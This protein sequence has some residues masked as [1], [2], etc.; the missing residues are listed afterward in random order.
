[1]SLVL[2]FVVSLLGG[3]A[4]SPASAA[5]GID[6]S[7]QLRHYRTGMGVSVEGYRK[8]G[9]AH[10]YENGNTMTI[11]W[12]SSVGAYEIKEKSTGLCLDTWYDRDD[13]YGWTCSGARSQR[14][15]AV[16]VGDRKDN[17]FYQQTESMYKLV[18]LETGE[19]LDG[20]FRAWTYT[21]PCNGGDWQLW[22][23]GP[24]WD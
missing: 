8:G 1:M 20:D 19:C 11:A 10:L 21:L 6:G 4:E 16:Y 7:G 3:V 5:Q 24:V 15:K 18:N 13:V 12:K 2:L 14:W 23:R 22:F 9:T 17:F